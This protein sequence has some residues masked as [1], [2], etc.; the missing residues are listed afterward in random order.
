M[1]WH[2]CDIRQHAAK[3]QVTFCVQNRRSRFEG[4]GVGGVLPLVL[5]VRACGSGTPDGRPCQRSLPLLQKNVWLAVA[6][7]QMEVCFLILVLLLNTGFFVI[8]LECLYIID[9]G[10]AK[11]VLIDCPAPGNCC[12]LSWCV[13]TVHLGRGVLRDRRGCG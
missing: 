12:D 6:P 11:L 3:L 9:C 8:F 7:Q 10:E 2:L 5:S 13:I 4:L 1:S